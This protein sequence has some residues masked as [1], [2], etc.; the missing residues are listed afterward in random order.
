LGRK[1]N[2]DSSCSLASSPSPERIDANVLEES[3][4]EKSILLPPD[5]AR[6]LA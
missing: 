1:V 4:L 5:S 3:P 6:D 2:G